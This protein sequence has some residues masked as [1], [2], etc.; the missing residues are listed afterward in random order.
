MP[1][2]TADDGAQIFYRDYDPGDTGGT[3]VVLSHG[4]PLNSDAWEAAARFL[5]EHGH[6]VIAHDRRGHGRSSQT[7]HGNEMDTY[8]DDLAALL[9]T[10]DLT[11]V[12]LV[13]HSTGGGEVVHYAGRHGTARIARIVLVSAVPPL[14][15]QGA[16]NPGGVPVEVFDGLRAGEAGNRSQLY[17]DLADGPFFGHNRHE[18]AQGFRDAFWLQSMACGHRAAYECIAAF[19]ATDFRPD[20]AKIDVPTLVIHGDDDQIVPFEVGGKRSAEMVSGAELKV[21]EGSGH[22]LPDTDRERL[23]TDLLTFINS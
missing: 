9:E 20:L 11:D 7:W 10:L 21:Y 1:F 18:V 16:D 15:Q 19:S 5:A 22:A 3:P 13:G 17:R 23:H 2:V 8:A 4:W 14:M 12:T 6:R